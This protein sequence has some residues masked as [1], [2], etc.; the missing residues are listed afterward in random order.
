MKILIT[1]A[2]GQLGLETSLAFKASGFDVTSVGRNEIDFLQPIKVTKSIVSFAPDWIINCAAYTQVDNAEDQ[3][4]QAFLINRDS[5]RAVAEAA[6]QC[7]SRLL[8]VSTDFI[9]CGSHAKPYT[10][11]EPAHP[12][13][14]YGQSKLEGEQ[15]IREVLPDALIV[16]TA[17]VYS[18]YRQNFVKTVLRL[19]AERSELKVV[20]DQLGTPTWT[21]D[22]TQAM[23]RLITINASGTFHFTNE[24]VAS[25]YDFA[26]EIITI[27][28]QLNY[29]VKLQKIYPISTKEYVTVATRPAYSVLNKEKIRAVLNYDIPHWRTSLFKMLQEM[30]P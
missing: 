30:R 7:H 26:H 2:H 13:G 25:W 12:L 18:T 14:I 11:I 1:G 10:E 19:A 20:D 4:E 29:P 17:W 28:K 22:I 5:A 8:H 23:H 6:K 15:A 21:R 3:P 9:F 16:R 27:A 24:G